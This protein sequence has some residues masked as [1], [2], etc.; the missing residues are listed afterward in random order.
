MRLVAGLMI[1]LLGHAFLRSIGCGWCFIAV[2][3]RFVIDYGNS[4]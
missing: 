1:I 2:F 4:I 3:T